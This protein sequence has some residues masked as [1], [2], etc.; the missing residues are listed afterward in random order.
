MLILWF[1][2]DKDENEDIQDS[3][4][5]ASGETE[6]SSERDDSPEFAQS[7][8][9]K[10]NSISLGKSH[11]SKPEVTT[12]PKESETI[13]L[14][15]GTWTEPESHVDSEAP[16]GLVGLEEEE[17]H[18]RWS[19]PPVLDEFDLMETDKDPSE[20]EDMFSDDRCVCGG[21]GGGRWVGVV[22]LHECKLAWYFAH[23]LQ[24]N[25]T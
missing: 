11:A 3:G 12:Q 9:T 17:D 21:G 22:Y 1:L 16:D 18:C 20:L 2:A 13:P 23:H 24:R 14:Q 15:N 25:I 6:P 5:E 8:T 10:S 7:K 19:F 4:I